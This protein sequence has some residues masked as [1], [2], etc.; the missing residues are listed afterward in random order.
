MFVVVPMA[1]TSR[2]LAELVQWPA[3]WRR[4]H[5]A[6]VWLMLA[7]GQR[8]T[9][10]VMPHSLNVTNGKET[11]VK[12]HGEETSASTTGQGT[13]VTTPRLGTSSA[14]PVIQPARTGR[15]CISDEMQENNETVSKPKQCAISP[16]VLKDDEFHEASIL[17]FESWPKP[18]QKTYDDG[19]PPTPW[20]SRNTLQLEE[21]STRNLRDLLGSGQFE[22]MLQHLLLGF[23]LLIR[24]DVYSLADANEADI[25]GGP[26][27]SNSGAVISALISAIECL[28]PVFLHHLITVSYRNVNHYGRSLSESCADILNASKD[29]LNLTG[30][31]KC[32][33]DL[34]ASSNEMNGLLLI[35]TIP[36]KDNQNNAIV[37]D[38][39]GSHSLTDITA[40]GAQLESPRCT[41]TSPIRFQHFTE[42]VGP[43][44]AFQPCVTS[45]AAISPATAPLP[46]LPTSAALPARSSIRS[47][48]YASPQSLA[49][50][51]RSPANAALFL[52][53][54]VSPRSAA[55]VS[56]RSAALASAR[57]P[58]SASP[59]S[60]ASAS[61]RSVGGASMSSSS[62]LEV[63]DAL[64]LDTLV[65]EVVRT[66]AAPQAQ[67]TQG[68]ALLQ[69]MQ[70]GY[71]FRVSANMS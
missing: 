17:S 34:N 19:V 18:Q 15:G 54:I 57:Y 27:N 9:Q 32:N 44:T 28:L 22:I 48:S 23:P 38:K 69:L 53:A 70:Q 51:S 31:V 11:A 36:A 39:T 37:I 47:P 50:A 3:V 42:G 14:S 59:R 33:P 35:D 45:A 30:T 2:G 4:L 40:S 7:Q 68:M 65:L 43:N 29:G 58:A 10:L 16:E 12:H 49:C 46:N 71:T 66:E 6:Y 25:N 56:P 61:S 41:N 63:F 8:I 26:K 20:L 1:V 64:D 60:P 55:S 62:S 21:I 13:S 67:H 5:S 52:S 24:A